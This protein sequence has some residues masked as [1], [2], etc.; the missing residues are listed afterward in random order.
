MMKK[1][2]I[3]VICIL[4]A[5]I[6]ILVLK[7]I[8][9]AGEFATLTPHA[10]Y[11]CTRVQHVPGPEDIAIDHSTGT[12]FISSF[13]R[14]A[15]MKGNLI[16]GAIFAYNLE[17]KPVMKN[18]TAGL[19]IGFYP[20]G[21]SFYAAP[22]GKKYLFVINHQKS[23]NYVELF[24]FRNNA[25]VHLE[26]VGGDL[27]ISPNDVTAVGPRQFYFTNDHGS[28]SDFGKLLEDYLQLSRSNVT[29]FDGEKL[30]VVAEGFA[31]ANGIWAA[32]DGKYLYVAATTG[33]KFYIYERS[34]DGSLRLVSEISLG[35]GGDNIDIGSGGTIRVAGHPK[36][37]TFLKHAKNEANKAP[38]QILE[39]VKDEKG[40][41]AFK[42]IYLNLGDEI[43]A[44]SVASVYKKRLLMG[45]VFEDYFLDCTMK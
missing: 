41:Y 37:L 5:G 44:A 13:N 30:R 12:A 33:K 10:D 23:K 1:K 39:I 15:F 38:S 21:I 25:L 27:M 11:K 9:D 22:D 3:I 19:K 16:Q 40:G 4:L 7:T 36:M 45:S 17:G 31:Y 35:S 29:F 8:R 14:R 34:A 26:T 2:I 20:H 42:E 32:D 24:E 18:L 6:T 43:S 28:K